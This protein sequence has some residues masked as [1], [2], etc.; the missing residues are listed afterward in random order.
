MSKMYIMIGMPG[1]G[2]SYYVKNH[3]KEGD[4]V[5]SRDTIRFSMLKD[6]EPYFAREKEV[7]R[8]FIR[9]INAAVAD[10]RDVWVDQTSINRASR[11]KLF[12]KLNKKPNEIIG[13][14]FTTPLVTA[15]ERNKQRTG[16]AFVPQDAI[17]NMYN[18][19]EKPELDEGFT[20]IMEVE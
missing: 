16:R 13:I 2:K 18:S 12:T 3:A 19:M 1:C 7:Y 8:E 4:I 15:I 9:Q 14:Y 10:E 20:E 5:V 6:N 17:I 11:N